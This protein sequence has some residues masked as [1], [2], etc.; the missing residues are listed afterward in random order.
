MRGGTASAIGGGALV[1][2]LACTLAL[3]QPKSSP[4]TPA[5]SVQP[6]QGASQAEVERGLYLTSL[7]DC[8]ACHTE[9]DGARFAGGRAVETPFGTV[10]S[11]NLTPDE[12][13][14]IGRYTLDTF[15]RALHEGIDK[16]GRHLFPAFPYNYYTNVTREDADAIYAYLRT[17]P[18]VSHAVDRNQLHFPFNIRALTGVW[19][20]MFLDRGPYRPN[21]EKSPAWNRGAYLAE[22][23]GHCQACHTPRNILGAPKKDDAYRGG[24]FGEWFAPDITPN[25]RTG[26]GAWDRDALLSFLRQ[27]L[28]GHSAAAAEMGEVVAFSTSQ[29]NDA[30]LAALVA[31]LNDRPPSPDVQVAKPADAVMRQGKAVW[32]DECSACHRMDG[33]GV[34][35]YFPPI[36][37]SANV[38]QA[39]PTT[40]LHYILAGAH[41]APTDRAPTPLSMPAFYWKL[42]DDQVAAVATYA[43]NSWG[44]EAQAVSADEVAKLR[45]K[46]RF[47][48][49]AGDVAHPTALSRPGPLTWAPADTLSPDNGTAAAG[50]TAPASASAPPAPSDAASAPSAASGPADTSASAVGRS[51]GGDGAN[52]HPVGV[53]ASGPS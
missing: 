40:V 41:R 24:T 36:K 47:G 45:T 28:N 37:A 9:K 1:A 53:P 7:G 25:R 2:V 17:I 46:L 15:Y 39:N 13:T 43:R 34:P 19:N 10:L 22:G 12:A 18:A 33:S 4:Q 6:A 30:D 35:R 51:S 44:N 5:A 11:A 21:A 42:D 16:D 29:M 23:L 3:G 38:Q 52:A 31:Y 48:P 50:R 26:L 49:T 27:G 20:W 8:V 32:E 14:G